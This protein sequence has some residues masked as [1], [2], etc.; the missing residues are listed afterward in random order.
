MTR[1][2]TMEFIGVTT[3]QSSVQGLFPRWVAAL[4]L[5]C[6]RLVGRD[7]P[8]DAEP[9]RYREAVERI[10]RDPAVRGALVTSHKVG[11]FTAAGDAFDDLD[12]LA[13]LCGE[14]SCISKRD[15]RLIGHAKDPVTSART[16][17][18]MLGPG[19]FAESG[20][21]VLCFGAGGAG[22]AITVCL[23]HGV[24]PADR[25]RRVVVADVRQERLAAARSVH[26]QLGT[27]GSLEYVRVEGPADALVSSMPR[28]SLV[29]NATGMGKDLPGSPV[30]DSARFP[31]GAVV[32][33]LNYR[34]A[35]DFLS[36]ARRQADQAGLRVEDGW[37]YFIHGWV[38]HIAEV[39]DLAW[40]S[41]RF[42]RMREVAGAW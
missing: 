4:G 39:F 30:T 33:D 28:G 26:D 1:Q 15:G 35:L 41:E 2:T 23:L 10:A 5:D 38:E 18:G 29:I 31:A 40:T 9:A 11:L 20:G 17:R 25:P 19:Y 3:S 13:R 6:A 32:W 27:S 36:Q 24:A 21:A 16:L 34:G 8:L 37:E 14:V 42:E 22:L 7:L 12:E